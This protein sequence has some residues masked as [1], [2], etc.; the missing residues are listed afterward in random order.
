MAIY[1]FSTAH[2]KYLCGDSI[3]FD[4]KGIPVMKMSPDEF[5]R[6]SHTYYFYDDRG[7]RNLEVEI[8]S[9]NYDTTY[10]YRKF[11]QSNH[12]IKQIQY[13]IT[14]KEYGRLITCD[15]KPQKDSLII[16][17]VFYDA[18]YKTQD[19]LP[20]E[21]R[22]ISLKINEDSTIESNTK[23]VVFA[24]TSY[25]S[26]YQDLYRIENKRLVSTKQQT[27]YTYNTDGDWIEKKTSDF[28]LKR[29]V[30]FYKPDDAEIR[31]EFRANPEV[32]RFLN[33]QID[34]IPALA[35]KKFSIKKHLLEERQKMIETEDYAT[36][37][38]LKEG[39]LLDDFTP[40]LWNLV[41]IDSG[42]IEAYQNPC[43]VAGY[44]TPMKNEDGF[45][46]RCLAIYVCKNGKYL[47]KKQSLG[48]LE[49]FMDDDDDLLFEGYNET[50]FSLALVGG[51]IVVSY[52]YMRGEATYTFSFEKG[53]WVLN[54]YDSS[55]RTCC[56]AESNSY[57][58]KTKEYTS[59]IF[60]TTEDDA[61]G[62]T[63]FTIIEERPVIYMDTE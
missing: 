15:L 30:C 32:I 19:V 9:N 25:N 62:D 57:S 28:S 17:L 55:H 50:N 24:D 16:N 1:I 39:I 45:N 46:L 51:S 43:I 42:Y 8:G 14:R 20:F 47:L 6:F 61:T 63:T 5:N 41:T 33:S 58:Y 3:L 22:S 53:K 12:M 31:F 38:E 18:D 2:Q 52:T 21:S 40:P 36:S 7:N 44:N 10:T 11:D 35:W 23:R 4:K 13:N 27:N 59:S 26:T 48:A 29:E 56:Q 54:S 49:S 60:S 37:I 34:S